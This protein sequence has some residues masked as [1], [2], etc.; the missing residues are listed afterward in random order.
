M[1]KFLF[2]IIISFSLFFLSACIS[3]VDISDIELVLIDEGFS[4]IEYQDSQ[5][6][7]MNQHLYDYCE[8][9]VDRVIEGRIEQ[10]TEV[11]IFEFEKRSQAVEFVE[12]IKNDE[13]S[14]VIN[15][16]HYIRYGH[17]VILAGSKE[18]IELFEGM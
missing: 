9:K 18:I 4:I 3:Y 2:A 13:F 8:C 6:Y 5:K 1:K 14:E 16:K 10:I 15:F 7:Q 12:L 11:Y 17:I